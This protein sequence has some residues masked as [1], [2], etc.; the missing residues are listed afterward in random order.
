M[1]NEPI[2]FVTSSPQKVETARRKLSRDVLV[3]DLK[4]HHLQGTALEVV[5]K[6]INQAREIVQGPIMVSVASLGMDALNGLPDTYVQDFHRK[7]DNEG[8]VN[9]LHAYEDKGAEARSVIGYSPGKGE[10][11]LFVS[12]SVKGHI[13]SPRGG[14]GFAWDP[15][16]EVCGKRMTFAEMPPDMMDTYSHL[17]RALD[18]LN[19]RLEKNQVKD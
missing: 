13:V 12:D 11:T 8:L 7:I 5:E 17:G 18:R 2:T 6:K 9:L 1:S 16:F 3:R 19:A 10:E 4:L 14:N 15:I